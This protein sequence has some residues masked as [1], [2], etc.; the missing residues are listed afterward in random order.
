MSEHDMRFEL[1]V[2]AT[3]EE[4][5]RQWNDAEARISWHKVADH[6]IVEASTDLRVG[7]AWRVAFGPSTNEMSV[8]EG[9]Y[10]FVD[11][12][13]RV[14]YTCVHRVAGRATF[15]TRVTVTFVASGDR[16]LVTLVDAGFPD[17]EM[18]EEFEGGWPSF[19]AFF[20]RVVAA[21]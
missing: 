13:H 1:L 2:D 11:P 9:V 6:W 18:R 20:A 5:F 4:A 12:P 19:L 21:R 14:V 17:D 10:E 3:P 8:E 16:T 15:R 7:G